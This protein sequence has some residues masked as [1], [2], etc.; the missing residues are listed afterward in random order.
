MLTSTYSN[1]KANLEK[2]I[3]KVCDDRDIA[4]ITNGP[5][6][7][8]LLSLDGYKAMTKPRAPKKASRAKNPPP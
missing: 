3:D 6:T 8:V 4:I 7:V 5:R 1:A 2:L